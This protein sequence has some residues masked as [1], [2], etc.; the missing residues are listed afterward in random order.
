MQEKDHN[1]VRGMKLMI[2]RQTRAA[3]AA[4][5]AA[6][7]EAAKQ[8]A[9]AALMPPPTSTAAATTPVPAPPG[10]V[11][12]LTKLISQ[13]QHKSFQERGQASMCQ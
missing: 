2:E 11:G 10:Q 7:E 3:A 6:S 9:E 5:G 4:A 8:L 13:L 12:S 1:R